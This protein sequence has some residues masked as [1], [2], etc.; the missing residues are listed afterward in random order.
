MKSTTTGLLP[1]NINIK[2]IKHKMRLL[3]KN[4]LRLAF[5]SLTPSVSKISSWSRKEL[6]YDI[7]RK[8]NFWILYFLHEKGVKDFRAF[9]NFLPFLEWSGL[10]P[11]LF[12]G[13]ILFRQ[14]RCIYSLSRRIALAKWPVCFSIIMLYKFIHQNCI[15]ILNKWSI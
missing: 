9:H 5:H 13:V 11:F 12:Y 7:S 14:C 10:F 1:I 2:N 15:N 8:D 6:L 4:L 3:F